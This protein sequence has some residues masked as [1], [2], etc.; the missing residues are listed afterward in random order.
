MGSSPAWLV[1][2]GMLVGY[3]TLL[4]ALGGHYEW[5]EL[6]V[7]AVSPGFFDL[8]SVTSGWDCA[9]QHLGAWPD[10]PCGPWQRPE[11]SWGAETRS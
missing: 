4:I 8:R 7:P 1:L 11:N 2:T 9:R 3:S 6:G 10:N 5:D